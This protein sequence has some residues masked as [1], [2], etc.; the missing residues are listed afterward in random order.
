MPRLSIIISALLFCAF[1]ALGGDAS[2]ASSTV[3]STLP[4]AGEVV[5]LTVKEGEGERMRKRKKEEEE[6]DRWS[7]DRRWKNSQPPLFALPLDSHYTPGRQLRRAHPRRHA[8]GLAR[9]CRGKEFLSLPLFYFPLYLEREKISSTST[10]QPLSLFLF[11]KKNLFQKGALVLALPPAR[12]HLEGPGEAP[13]RRGRQR[14]RQEA[15][16]GHRRPREAGR[17]WRRRRERR[18][19]C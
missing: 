15:A 6:R 8:H 10:F 1:L 13:R 5:E 16:Q 18:S 9:H 17:V 11:Q 4:P 19:S 2:A 3:V 12:A 7:I 14:G